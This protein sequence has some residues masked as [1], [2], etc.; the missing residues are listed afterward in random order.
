MRRGTTALLEAP[1]DGDKRRKVKSEAVDAHERSKD[2]L[3]PPE[4]DR[5]L[6]A[7]KAGRHG[8]R[9]HLLLLMM[10]RHA[11]RV[12]EAVTMRQ[13]QLNLKQSRIWI[14]RSKNSL[15]TEQA[16]EGDELRA[17]KRYL[18]SSQG[19]VAVVVRVRARTADDAAGRKLLDR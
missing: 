6:E 10:Y 12:S 16:M 17:V 7:A 2:Y 15:S 9:D 4:V 1:N 18:A 8:I 19:Q 11:M 14:R 5:L 13:D 3:D